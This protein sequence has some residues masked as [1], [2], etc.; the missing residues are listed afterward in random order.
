MTMKVQDSQLVVSIRALQPSKAFVIFF[1]SNRQIFQLNKLNAGSSMLSSI[2]LSPGS[3]ML[4]K[5]YSAAVDRASAYLE[6]L[7]S[8]GS[9]KRGLASQGPP[10]IQITVRR[11]HKTLGQEDVILSVNPEIS[12]QQLKEGCQRA[13]QVPITSQ[14]ILIEEE[15]SAEDGGLIR[16]LRTTASQISSRERLVQGAS[17]WINFLLLPEAINRELKGRGIS[18]WFKQH[19]LPNLQGPPE[20]HITR[21]EVVMLHDRTASFDLSRTATVQRL[22]SAVERTTS[23]PLDKQRILILEKPPPQGMYALFWMLARIIYQIAGIVAAKGADWARWVLLGPSYEK[24]TLQLKLQTEQGNEVKL[25][26]R[27]DMTIAQLQQEL[28][29]KHGDS[30]SLEG[31]VLRGGGSEA[32]VSSGTTMAGF[33]DDGVVKVH[34]N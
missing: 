11:A 32:I 15:M 13:T 7:T 29:L 20:P 27:Q 26:V 16:A 24:Q 19:I 14:Q 2:L 18:S 4:N 9:R 3:S 1:T 33:D 17:E 5:T 25:A 31:L 22:K 28:Q 12:L 6:P 10:P 34:M 23:V 8:F 30:V 21:V